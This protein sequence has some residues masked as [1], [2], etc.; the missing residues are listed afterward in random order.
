MEHP[1]GDIPCIEVLTQRIEHASQHK[2]QGFEPFDWPL[3]RNRLLESLLFFLW[4]EWTTIL[5]TCDPLQLHT[6]LSQAGEQLVCR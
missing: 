5:T 2:G 4:H 1:D 3:E 6:T